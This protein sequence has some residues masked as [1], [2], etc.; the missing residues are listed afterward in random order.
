LKRYPAILVTTLHMEIL[1]A[2]KP[3]LV[4][5]KPPRDPTILKCK[6]SHNTFEASTLSKM[7]IFI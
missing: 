7:G 5:W 6:N 3:I 4:V 2:W 1:K